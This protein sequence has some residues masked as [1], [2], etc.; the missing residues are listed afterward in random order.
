MKVRSIIDSPCGIRFLIESLPLMSGYS[1]YAFLESKLMDSKD[2]ISESYLHTESYY[3]LLIDNEDNKSLLEMLLSKLKEV[4]G[5]QGTIDKLING[6][7]IDDV[8]LFEVKN[9]AL[10]SIDIADLLR[11]SGIKYLIPPSLEKVVNILDPD[12]LKI[13]SFY[14]YSS[15][16]ERLAFIRS[17]VSGKI[18][19]GEREM[20]L[21]ESFEIENEIRR[22]LSAKLTPY[23]TMLKETLVTLVGIDIT[24]AKATLMKE[25]NLILPQLSSNGSSS[26]VG[27]FHPQVKA[28]LEEK[29]EQFQNID[30]STDNNPTIIIGANMGGKTVVLKTLALCQYSTRLGMP[31]PAKSAKIAVKSDVFLLMGDG[32]SIESGFSSFASEMKRLDSLLVRVRKGENLLVLLDEPAKTT[33]PIEGSALVSALI[34][35]LE[36]EGVSSVITTH[37]NIEVSGCNRLK[38]K[39]LENGKMNYL[40][41]EAP[42]GVVPHE[43]LEVAKMLEID[44]E[45]IDKANTILN[46]K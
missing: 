44:R 34:G 26:F 12:G 23:A 27:M 38:V 36:S 6:I 19:E 18:D 35:I 25:M 21:M 37:Y 39:G 22:G 29:G 8:E 7:T 43:A 13:S 10:L 33:N 1:R 32:Q 41:S 40:L 16:S 2:K 31:I 42:S 11:K 15:Y 28:L 17:K 14:I 5:I 45:W 4:K 3:K 30:I 46:C 24:I 9:L 20:L